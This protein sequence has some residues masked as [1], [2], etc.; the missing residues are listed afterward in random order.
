MLGKHIVKNGSKI[1]ESKQE[2]SGEKKDAYC[3]FSFLQSM[4]SAKL[5][6][7]CYLPCY[8]SQDCHHTHLAYA[9]THVNYCYH[10]LG[11]T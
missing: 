2:G 7:T 9:E 6:V 1:R 3:R 4:S 8:L 10:L 11:A 5:L